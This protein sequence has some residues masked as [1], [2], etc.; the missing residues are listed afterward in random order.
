MDKKIPNVLVIGAGM[1]VCGRGTS[2]LG[3]ILPTL[4]QN[5]KQGLINDIA[6]AATNHDSINTMNLQLDKINK[7]FGTTASVNTYP[8]QKENDTDAYK[9]A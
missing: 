3:T 5:Q 8:K 9:Q 6:V 2:N 1:Y 4:I 7:V